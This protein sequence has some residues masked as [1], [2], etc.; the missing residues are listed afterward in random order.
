[1]L[2]KVIEAP[3]DTIIP[4]PATKAQPKPGINAA[5]AAEAPNPAAPEIVPFIVSV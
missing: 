4:A 2:S 5:T 3:I 1:M